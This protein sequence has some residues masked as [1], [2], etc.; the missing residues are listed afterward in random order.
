MAIVIKKYIVKFN[1]KTLFQ[2]GCPFP[3]FSDNTHGFCGL[4][5]KTQPSLV[6]PLISQKTILDQLSFQTS[7]LSF[8]IYILRAYFIVTRE[9]EEIRR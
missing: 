7:S 3:H 1:S 6:H 8:E 4:S 9:I 2:F 5:S